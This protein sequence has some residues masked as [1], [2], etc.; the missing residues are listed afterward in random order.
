MESSGHRA[1]VLRK[2]GKS[3]SMTMWN[4]DRLLM[5]VGDR[6]YEAIAHTYPLA[7][8]RAIST[9]TAPKP[10]N[11]VYVSGEGATTT[12]G[13]LTPH[14]AKI[15]GQTESDLLALSKEEAF[16]N[17]RPFSLRPAG[18]DPTFHKEIQEFIPKRTGL[19]KAAEGALLPVLRGVYTKMISPTKDLG[20]VLTE[21]A[22]GSGEKHD[23]KE[24]GVSG[25]GRT[26]NNVA[27][28]RLA[29]I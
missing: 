17:L 26:L 29:G 4:R 10:I 27:M 20:R 19:A 23:E 11:F 21:L 8:A 18:V 14:W 5:F 1:S 7:F 9:T 16:N 3:E 28:R 22:A 15:K 25:E 13:F 24:S 2:L 6:E 12:P